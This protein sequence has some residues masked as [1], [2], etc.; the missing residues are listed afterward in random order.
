[1]SRAFVKETDKE[2]LP[3][4]PP[5]AHLP[6]G[7]PNYVTPQGFASL[8]EELKQLQLEKQH[9]QDKNT[10]GDYT[11]QTK[12]EVHFGATVNL[13]LD[14]VQTTQTFK[15][16]G[17]DE[18]NI[19]KGKI[20]FTSPLAKALAGKQQHEKAEVKLPGGI[21]TFTILSISYED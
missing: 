14:K 13:G 1:M 16:V 6:A 7:T 11:K 17:V 3:L 2:E 20:A 21:Q 19:T 9:L 4:V 10:Q 18:A 15:I 12:N 8:Q 5:R